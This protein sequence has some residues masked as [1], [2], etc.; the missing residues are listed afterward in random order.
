MEEEEVN[1][2]EDDAQE[3]PDEPDASP[4]EPATLQS[5]T[6]PKCQFDNHDGVAHCDKCGVALPQSSIGEEAVT[7]VMNATVNDI[8]TNMGL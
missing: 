6:C 5:V 2:S 4:A 3:K 1:Y 7:L 8:N